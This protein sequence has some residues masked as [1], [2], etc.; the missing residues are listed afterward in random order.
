MTPEAT[1]AVPPTSYFTTSVYESERLSFESK[2]EF[3]QVYQ[4]RL[5]SEIHHS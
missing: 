4:Y 1:Q 2:Y 5:V 3:T